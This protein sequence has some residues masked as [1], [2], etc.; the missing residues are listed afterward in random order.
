MAPPPCLVVPSCRWHVCEGLFGPLSYVSRMKFDLTSTASTTTRRPR[1]PSTWRPSRSQQAAERHVTPWCRAGLC[2]GWGPTAK[3]PGPSQRAS[4]AAEGC[5]R[6]ASAAG[7][8]EGTYWK[9]PSRI[10]PPE[11][12]LLGE[13][14]R[15]LRTGRGPTAKPLAAYHLRSSACTA[16]CGSGLCAQGGAL[17]QNPRRG[18]LLA[19]V[20]CPQGGAL[21]ENPQLHTTSGAVLL[22]AWERPL[23]TGRGPT[24]KPPPLAHHGALYSVACG[25]AFGH[26]EGSYGKT[27]SRIPHPELLCSERGSGSAHGCRALLRRV[28]GLPLRAVALLGLRPLPANHSL[29]GQP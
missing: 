13:W 26:R 28:L 20:R 18:R 15:P 24:A 11:Q 8:R 7:H 1:A 12:H 19:A 5:R 21:L 17:Q 25:A 6:G 16:E 27:P 2:T 9:T 29:G 10:P 14:E 23:R 22:G 3:P 4:A